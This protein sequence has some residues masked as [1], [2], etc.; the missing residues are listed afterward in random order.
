MIRYNEENTKRADVAIAYIYCDGKDF[1]IKP[2]TELFFSII[3]LSAKQ[4]RS[5]PPQIKIHRGKWIEKWKLS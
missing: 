5:I 2:E 1:I 4:C 3:R